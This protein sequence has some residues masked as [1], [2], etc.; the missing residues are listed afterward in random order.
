MHYLPVGSAR[1]D[2]SAS[3]RKSLLAGQY[4][5]L[6]LILKDTGMADENS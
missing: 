4:W 3:P 2:L 6:T 1:R 5:T